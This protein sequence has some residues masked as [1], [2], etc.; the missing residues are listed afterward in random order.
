MFLDI[1][2]GEL[3]HVKDHLNQLRHDSSKDYLK[4]LAQFLPYFL[5]KMVEAEVKITGPSHEPSWFQEVLDREKPTK[6]KLL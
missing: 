4:T 5:P 2:E 3:E 6:N 1:M